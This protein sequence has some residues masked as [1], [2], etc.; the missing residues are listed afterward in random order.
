MRDKILEV[1]NELFMKQGY[2]L[3]STRQIAKRLGVT[4]PAIYFHFHSKEE[5]YLEVVLEFAEH[6]GSD[7]LELLNQN[8]DPETT[9]LAMTTVLREK[10]P[11]N[12]VMMMHDLKNELT[13][14]TQERIYGVWRTNFFGP[15]QTV[16]E[17]MEEELQDGYTPYHVTTHFLRTIQTYVSSDQQYIHETP[18]ELSQ[19]IHIFIKG[20]R[21]D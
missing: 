12:F 2:L 18:L 19:I 21:K 3:T 17:H 7:L 1:A 14:E 6:L 5:I 9:L 15:F 20:I 16:F 4:Q 8:E 10:Y 11:L 13:R